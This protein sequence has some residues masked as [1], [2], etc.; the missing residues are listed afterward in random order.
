MAIS[1][2]WMDML[3]IKYSRIFIELGVF[4]LKVSVTQVYDVSHVYKIHK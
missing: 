3:E 1:Q 4:I 2:V